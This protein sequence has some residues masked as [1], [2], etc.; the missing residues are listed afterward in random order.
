[1][2]SS[3]LLA[4]PELKGSGVKPGV[5]EPSSERRVSRGTNQSKAQENSR[6]VHLDLKVVRWGVLEIIRKLVE[7]STVAK[8]SS[9]MFG[10]HS[11]TTS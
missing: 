10:S 8:S 7:C 2:S 11:S 5:I 4:I 6:I 3:G 9:P 1:M